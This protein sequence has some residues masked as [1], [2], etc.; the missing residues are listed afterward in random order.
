MGNGRQGFLLNSCVIEFPHNTMTVQWTGVCMSADVSVP[1]DHWVKQE[2]KIPKF[3]FS[4]EAVTYM[5]T[6]AR[7]GSNKM[8]SHQLSGEGNLPK[9]R[10]TTHI[11]QHNN[12]KVK[13]LKTKLL[14]H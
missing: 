6:S 8:N 13:A 1:K 2:A 3:H 7:G 14:P 4:P 5:A 12:L 11:H 9:D 10:K